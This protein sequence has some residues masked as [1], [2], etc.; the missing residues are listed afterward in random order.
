[1]LNSKSLE[2]IK[3]TAL[4]STLAGSSMDRARG[5][6]SGS[7]A[8]M[9]LGRDRHDQT[10]MPAARLMIQQ[11]VAAANREENRRF[12]IASIV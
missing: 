7:T 9:P 3:S 4:A 6:F 12:R 8:D 5:K 11:I 2:P 10:I 1:M